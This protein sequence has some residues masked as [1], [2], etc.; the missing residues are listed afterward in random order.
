MSK[1]LNKFLVGAAVGVGIG[2]LIAPKKGSETREDL[3]KK[4]LEE[5]KDVKD[6]KITSTYLCRK[7]KILSKKYSFL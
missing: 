3:K 6:E 5:L 4:I 7:Y 1:G 2:V